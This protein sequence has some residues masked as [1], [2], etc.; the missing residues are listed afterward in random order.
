MIPGLLV[1]KN[2]HHCWFSRTA[3]MKDLDPPYNKQPCKCIWYKRLYY[4][5]SQPSFLSELSI[6]FNFWSNWLEWLTPGWNWR[7]F[8]LLK[9]F[10]LEIG[11]YKGNYLEV[12]FALIG[13][14]MEIIITDL[15]SEKL[16]KDA[17]EFEEAISTRVADIEL[18]SPPVENN[19]Q[20]TEEEHTFI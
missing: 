15:N 5:I 14:N 20:P 9:I 10:D 11:E 17:V 7:N 3:I 12:G 19:T 4:L 18:K 16:E 6:H 8:T 2:V 13:F 1:P